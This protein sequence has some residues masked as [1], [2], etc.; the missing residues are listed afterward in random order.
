MQCIMIRHLYSTFYKA[1]QKCTYTNNLSK[2]CNL[3]PVVWIYFKVHSLF[4]RS[5]IWPIFFPVAKI[6]QFNNTNWSSSLL[7]TFVAL[8]KQ[9]YGPFWVCRLIPIT[10]LFHAKFVSCGFCK[11]QHQTPINQTSCAVRLT[12]NWKFH[13]THFDSNTHTQQRKRKAAK[14]CTYN[15]V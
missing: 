9:G 8:I 6:L 4:S 1:Q 7:S 13:T 12:M 2:C 11:P 15:G 3:C 14:I 10:C 5:C